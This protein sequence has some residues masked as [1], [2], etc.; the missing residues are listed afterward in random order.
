[1]VRIAVLGLGS[2]GKNYRGHLSRNPHVRLGCVCDKYRHKIDQVKG[3]WHV[4]GDT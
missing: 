2:S 4:P 1:M 3:R